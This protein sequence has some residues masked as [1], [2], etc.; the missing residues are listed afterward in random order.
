[1]FEVQSP[2][3]L[4]LIAE[5]LI[6]YGKDDNYKSADVRVY[7]LPLVSKWPLECFNRDIV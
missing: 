1:M 5:R 2:G 3:S 4:L 7:M 6:L